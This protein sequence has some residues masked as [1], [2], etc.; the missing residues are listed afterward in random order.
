MR[1]ASAR[2]DCVGICTDQTDQLL[3]VRGFFTLLLH[4]LSRI[5]IGINYNTVK[6][7]S[8]LSF[9]PNIGAFL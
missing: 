7:A 1:P 5:S 6:D 9:I 4:D 2:S 3:Y 8:R